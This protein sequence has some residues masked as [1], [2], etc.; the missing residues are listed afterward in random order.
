MPFPFILPSTLSSVFVAPVFSRSIPACFT[1]VFKDK[2]APFALFRS[3]KTSWS[4]SSWL[5]RSGL[6]TVSRKLPSVR[7][8]LVRFLVR[9]VTGTK[10]LKHTN[11]ISLFRVRDSAIPAF[12]IARANL[13]VIARANSQLLNK[14]DLLTQCANQLLHRWSSTHS[15]DQHFATIVASFHVELIARK[16]LACRN[17]S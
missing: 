16:R 6:S 1:V 4:V 13:F 5:N 15:K 2:K 17:S 3:R 8:L 7:E 14:S 12:A 10:F 11:N 9:R